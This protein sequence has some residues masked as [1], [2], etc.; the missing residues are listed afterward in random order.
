LAFHTHNEHP[1]SIFPIVPRE[2]LDLFGY[3][4]PHSLSDAWL[5]Q[6]AYLLDI[7]QRID[8]DVL[9]DRFDLTGNNKDETFENRPMLEGNP[10]D[11]RDF[12]NMRW[13]A[14]RLE[15]VRTIS[16][17]MESKG[18]DTSFYKAVM[19]GKQDPWEKLKLNDTNKQMSQFD[20]KKLLEK[21]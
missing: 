15:D 7:L 21:K 16:K 10:K 19:T 18:L 1:Y 17:Y 4:S 20:L 12:H 2:W 9:H 11:P 14:K 5:S 8:V 13:Q 3:M 6:Q